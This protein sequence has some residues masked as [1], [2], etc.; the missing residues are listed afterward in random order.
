MYREFSLRDQL[1]WQCWMLTNFAMNDFL[2]LVMMLRLA[3]HTWRRSGQNSAINPHTEDR[4]LPLE[5]GACDLRKIVPCQSR[6]P[7]DFT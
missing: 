2:L 1:H 5:R 6:R 4:R 3:L 7:I